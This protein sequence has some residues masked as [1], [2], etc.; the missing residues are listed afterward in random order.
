MNYFFKKTATIR[1]ETETEKLIY[2]P[3]PFLKMP[4]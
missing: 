1:I 4:E 3:D 2:R